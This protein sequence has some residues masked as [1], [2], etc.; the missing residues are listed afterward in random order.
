MATDRIREITIR[1]QLLE[2]NITKEAKTVVELEGLAE[3]LDSE[4]ARNYSFAKLA[5]A[6]KRRNMM[7][8]HR[9]RLEE[10]LNSTVKMTRED[11]INSRLEELDKEISTAQDHEDTL[12]G[13]LDEV[14]DEAAKEDL[15]ARLQSAKE[16][17]RL[18]EKERDELETE[19]ADL[20]N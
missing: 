18:L 2:E 3:R 20:K 10:E 4:W 12:E 5:D 6:K 17:T 19:L 14:E 15:K 11:E 7:K 9:S 13:Y 16:N 1:L 8:S